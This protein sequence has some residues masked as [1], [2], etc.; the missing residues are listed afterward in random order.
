[1]QTSRRSMTVCWSYKAHFE[2]M[3]RRSSE[4]KTQAY[5]NDLFD[6]LEGII[7][8]NANIAV[9]YEGMLELQSTL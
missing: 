7:V 2:F 9:I 3:R 5:K 8:F 1:M 6:S 4:E